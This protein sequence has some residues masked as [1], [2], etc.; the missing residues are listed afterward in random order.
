M[1]Y[2]TPT[3]CLY[4]EQSY[5]V[6]LLG[7]LSNA[8]NPVRSFYWFPYVTYTRYSQNRLNQG[9]N[10]VILFILVSMVTH[11]LILL[12]SKGTRLFISF[13]MLQIEVSIIRLNNEL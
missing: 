3:L 13:H 1:L 11:N 8:S 2:H 12:F 9:R 4:S 7:Y 5:D 10:Q 6:H